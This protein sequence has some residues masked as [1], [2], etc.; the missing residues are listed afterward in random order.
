MTEA[1][2]VSLIGFET[3]LK[4]DYAADGMVTYKT[5]DPCQADLCSYEII[6]YLETDNYPEF[7]AYDRFSMF[8]LKYQISEVI[9]I[10][11]ITG[12]RKSIYFKKYINN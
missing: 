6:F 3:T 1:D 12:D 5:V 11:E 10:L 9:Q 7:F 2:I 8:L 4:F